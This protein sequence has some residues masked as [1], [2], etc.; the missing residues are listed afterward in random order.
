MPEQPERSFFWTLAQR[1]G[2]QQRENQLSSTFAA[3]FTQSLWF[4]HVVIDVVRQASRINAPLRRTDWVCSEQ[5]CPP[6]GGRWRIDLR[7]SPAPPAD[8]IPTFHLESK[9]ESPLTE[10]QVKRYRKKGAEYLIAV[11][12]HPPEV[13]ERRL[14]QL[15]AHAVR[16][17]D[18]HR[19]LND[20]RPTSH[21][22]EFIR[23]SFLTFLEELGMAHAED[24][25]LSDLS[26]LVEHFNKLRS[27]K[28]AYFVP[29]QSFQI[30]DALTD[31]LAEVRRQF[32]EASPVTEKYTYRWGPGVWLYFDEEN[33]EKL[34]H[35]AF[36]WNLHRYGWRKQVLAAR[37]KSL[38]KGKSDAARIA[39]SV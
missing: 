4:R 13:S 26:K 2:S 8:G 7:V 25:R 14:R 10:E 19:A 9:V 23:S 36:G 37:G 5:V 17:Q 24:L 33:P 22:D 11:T 39:T 6:K 30:A 20:G 16:W 3:C 1:A 27:P 31:F 34:S 12:K 29:K 38:S 18:I 15:G 32:M 28:Y 35:Y 21:V